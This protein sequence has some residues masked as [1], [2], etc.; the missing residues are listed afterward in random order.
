MSLLVNVK[1]GNVGVD[2]KMVVHEGFG[3]MNASYQVSTFLNNLF[4]DWTGKSDTSNETGTW[5]FVKSRR[6][7]KIVQMNY[8]KY[9]EVSLLMKYI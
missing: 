7:T 8:S 1:Y 4:I 2:F 5:H 3:W 9:S 6:V